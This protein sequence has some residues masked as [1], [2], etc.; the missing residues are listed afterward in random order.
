[1]NNYFNGYNAMPQYPYGYQANMQRQGQ[2]FNNQMPQPQP[3]NMPM[4]PQQPQMQPPM[5]YDMPINYIGYT[6]LKEAEAHI[7]F[8]NQK[9]IFIDKANGMVYEKVCGQDGQSEI[10]YYK[11]YEPQAENQAVETPKEQATIDLSNYVERKELGQFASLDDYNKLL[12][13][14]EQLQK[15]V[16]GVRNNVGTSKQ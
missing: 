9:A 15:Q 2:M 1:M 8:P 6:N 10:T 13:K 3:M 16:M 12:L 4:Q 7:L 5:Q 11:K 14:V